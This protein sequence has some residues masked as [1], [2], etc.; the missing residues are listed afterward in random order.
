M[1]RFDPP[2]DAAADVSG[3]LSGR[4]GKRLGIAVAVL[5]VLF[6]LRAL[7]GGGPRFE[8]RPVGEPIDPTWTLRTPEGQRVLAGE[9]RGRTVL[10]NVWASWCPPCFV[11]MPSLVRLGQQLAGR[12]DILLVLVSTDESLE[13]VEDAIVQLGLENSPVY[14]PAGRVPET[15]PDRYLPS[16]FVIAPDGR[17][18][19]Q[20]YGAYEWDNPRVLAFLEEVAAT[21]R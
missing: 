1:T 14:V 21:A 5:A 3:D 8:M 20:H 16:T 18:V 9:W 15:I 13:I 2:P 19:F 10:V 6:V 11:E 17:I 7:P 12:D 4:I